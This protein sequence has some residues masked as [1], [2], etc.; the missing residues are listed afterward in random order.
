MLGGIEGPRWSIYEWL[1]PIK[2]KPY[3]TTYSRTPH[4]LKT[5]SLNAFMGDWSIYEWYLAVKTWM[6]DRCRECD[7]EKGEGGKA[8]VD[9]DVNWTP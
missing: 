2:K 9:E 3:L 8:G 1:L 5:M 4:S 6:G 7:G